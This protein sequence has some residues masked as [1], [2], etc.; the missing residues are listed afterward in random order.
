MGGAILAHA[1]FVRLAKARAQPWRADRFA[2]PTTKDVDAK[3]V[4][5]SAIFG[6]GWGLSGFCPGPSLVGVGSL[7]VYTIV[8]VA[9][10]VVGAVIGRAIANAMG[11]ADQKK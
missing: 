3:L 10:V 8:F 2:W 4:V 7:Y 1:P 6:V 9:A 11:S 5:G